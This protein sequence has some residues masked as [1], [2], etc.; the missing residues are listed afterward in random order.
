MADAWHHLSDSLSSIGSFLGIL[1]ARLGFPVLDP[2]AAIIICL[3]IFKVALDIFR[4][5]AGKMTDK[6]CDEQTEAEMRTLILSH[7]AVIDIDVLKTRLFGDRI[8]VDVE[9]S[10]D[11]SETL[12]QA[13]ETAHTVHDAI[14]STF[15]Q[16]KHC[17]VHT[18]PAIESGV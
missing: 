8:Y 15:P 18:N 11:A 5:A 14:E 7:E 9:I 16:V 10:V 17:T 12:E 3:F 2:V 6:A 4:D 1:G 13:Q